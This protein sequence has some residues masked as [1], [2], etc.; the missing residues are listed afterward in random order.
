MGGL[1]WKLSGTSRWGDGIL[2]GEPYNSRLERAPSSVRSEPR[3]SVALNPCCN[4]TKGEA[5]SSPALLRVCGRSREVIRAKGKFWR[6][7]EGQ[8]GEGAEAGLSTN[9]VRADGWR[10]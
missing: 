2:I 3:E 9:A 1:A 7:S 8:M 10:G 5:V 4:S 6:R